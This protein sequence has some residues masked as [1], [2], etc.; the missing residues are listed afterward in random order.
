MHG[1]HTPT[2][3]DDPASRNTGNPP[4]WGLTSFG[5]LNVSDPMLPQVG[6]R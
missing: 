3:R 6:M 1:F 4:A 5:I 2:L